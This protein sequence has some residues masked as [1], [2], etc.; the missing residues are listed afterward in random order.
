[1]HLKKLNSI[2]L[3]LFISLLLN[4]TSFNSIDWWDSGYYAALSHSL[5]IP[6]QG[7]S[8]LYVIL[9]K[10][11][12]TLLF[13]L[14]PIKAIIHLSIMCS[15]LSSVFFYHTLLNI[16]QNIKIVNRENRDPVE[17]IVSFITALTLP[18]LYSIWSKSISCNVYIL[19]LL[20]TSLLFYFTVK[21]WFSNDNKLNCIYL[22]FIVY[23][24]GVDF[25]SHRLNMP[26][27]IVLFILLIVKFKTRIFS[28]KLLLLAIVMFGLG[29]SLHI[30][31]F[32][33]G[34]YD[35]IINITYIENRNDFISWIKMERYVKSNIPILFER[36]APF[37][38]YQIG[39]MYLR[40]LKWNL[41]GKDSTNAIFFINAIPCLFCIIGFIF[42]FFK[43][44]NILVLLFSSFLSYSFLL[45][46]YLNIWN[47]FFREIDRLFLP[48]F[49]IIHFWTGIGLYC[50]V[51]LILKNI[52]K[53]NKIYTTIMFSVF[54]LCLITLPL[55]VF[56]QNIKKCDK[57]KD[58][59]AED[60]SYNLLNSCA[61][62]AILFTN[63]DN[64]TFPLLYLQNVCNIRKD[65]RVVNK[66]LLGIKRYVKNC[67]DLEPKT[68]ISLN[69]KQLDLIFNNR[70]NHHYYYQDKLPDAAIKIRTKVKRG[71]W[72]VSEEIICDI[73]NT[74]KWQK[75]IYF[76]YIPKPSIFYYS[77]FSQV[78]IAYKLIP[79]NDNSPS[80]Y[81][82]NS[83][84]NEFELNMMNKYK[85]R[86]INNKNV[87]VEKNEK[88]KGVSYLF[89]K[90][91]RLA[92][93]KLI[94]HYIKLNNNVKAKKIFTVMNEKV[95]SWRFS[96]EDNDRFKSLI[97]KDF[98][99]N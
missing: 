57:R 8:I 30:Y 39:N 29:F 14:P 74:N 33:R 94:D 25:S 9:G 7:G 15:A 12:M 93:Y 58:Y 48:S 2:I 22:I 85:F 75:P 68:P 62:N 40:Y 76:S 32:M 16:L 59:F 96:K 46:I 24:L 99:S 1:M 65:V 43:K 47:N 90:N 81:Y 44:R 97:P 27:V 42:C 79:E 5:G 72:W 87:W 60:Y 67:R 31:L 71:V 49:L 34:N 3:F 61:K 84:I 19:G 56:I 38:T 53:S 89:F 13:F 37:W 78:G 95:P 55:N 73:I 69:N 86:Y 52:K 21:I 4:I 26:Y 17:E 66:K 54:I 88:I 98:I 64:D 18:F 83:H 10:V 28:Y 36:R 50:L 35:N 91:Y 6:I 77:N 51:S 82:S 80:D 23:I 45:A 70:K 41:I 63:G 20:I 11:F 92:F